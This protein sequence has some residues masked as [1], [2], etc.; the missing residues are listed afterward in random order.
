MVDMTLS[1]LE[2]KVKVIRFGMIDSSYT[3]SYGLS[4][5]TTFSL[6]LIV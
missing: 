2:T 5:V 4:I 1:D 3:T 6:G